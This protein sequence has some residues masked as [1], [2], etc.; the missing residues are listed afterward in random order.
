MYYLQTPLIDFSAWPV[1]LA[2]S[3]I[4]IFLGRVSPLELVNRRQHEH[5]VDAPAQLVEGTTVD[6]LAAEHN[7]AAGRRPL[8][9]VSLLCR[10]WTRIVTPRVHW[11]TSLMSSY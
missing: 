6:Q 3:A 5:F 8:S 4:R 10:W 11:L 1:S 9:N 7:G 2:A